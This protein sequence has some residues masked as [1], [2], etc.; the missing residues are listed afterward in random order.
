MTSLSRRVRV[1][2]ERV[3]VYVALLVVLAVAVFA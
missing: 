3:A 1:R 2:A